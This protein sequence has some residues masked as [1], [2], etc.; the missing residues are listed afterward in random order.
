MILPVL[1]NTC[2]PA[3]LT[4]QWTEIIYTCC[5]YHCFACL[6]ARVFSFSVL[7]DKKDFRSPNLLEFSK[8]PCSHKKSMAC[9]RSVDLIF[10]NNA[11]LVWNI[12]DKVFP[13]SPSETTIDIYKM[14]LS[15]KSYFVI[16]KRSVQCLGLFWILLLVSLVCLPILPCPRLPNFLPECLDLAG[17]L[18]WYSW[19][20]AVSLLFLCGLE[21]LTL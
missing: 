3:G 12:S 14:H 13:V 6:S 21:D 9:F 15:F 1:G 10:T 4:A 19:T 11:D 8:K 20:P 2:L 5:F 17:V 16:G 18:L 7:P